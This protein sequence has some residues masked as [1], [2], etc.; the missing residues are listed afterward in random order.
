M[1]L[2][3]LIAD[4]EPIIRMGLK[5]MLQEL[6]H[7]VTAAT[8]GR[9]ALRMVRR[10]TFD[11]AILDIKM[12]YTDG[13]QAAETLARTSPLPIIILTAY[14][15]RDLIEQASD[16]PIHA[17]LVKPVHTEQLAAA[18]AVACKRFAEAESNRMQADAL[19]QKLKR[20]KTIDRAK[21]K[22]METGLSEQEAYRNIRRRARATRRPMHEI[23][24]D[25]L[26]EGK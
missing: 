25:I 23:A 22:L 15:Q 19:R 11:L 5:A 17:Y 3:V 16:L 1:T 9:E 7:T 4:D 10:R 24:R 26:Q 18:I 6:G 13:L 21:L 8:N 20:Q 14:S 12:P 2:N